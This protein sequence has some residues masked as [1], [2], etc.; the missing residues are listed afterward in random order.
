MR[1]DM[2]YAE[3]CAKADALKALDCGEIFLSTGE[4]PWHIATGC[5]PGGTHRLDMDTSVWFHGECP[6]T[7]LF[8]RWSFDIEPYSASGKGSYEIDAEAC[9]EVLS[10]LNGAC[11]EVFRDYLETCAAKVRAKGA[12]YQTVADR[13]LRDANTLSELARV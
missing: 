5:R 3:A 7:G 6:K 13:Q 12:E 11:R 9:R 2:T 1:R 10:K 4:M 8:F